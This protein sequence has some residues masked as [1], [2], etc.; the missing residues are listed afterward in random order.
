MPTSTR[1]LTPNER[2]WKRIW[3]IITLAFGSDKD[4]EYLTT[5]HEHQLRHEGGQVFPIVSTFGTRIS[6]V[7]S[8]TYATGITYPGRTCFYI[9][10]CEK[11]DWDP[12]QQY[13]T[14]VTPEVI[15]VEVEPAIN[16]YICPTCGNDRCNT[17]ERT[18][19]KCGNPL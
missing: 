12:V 17:K 3:D 8:Y 15:V 4:W 13:P 10:V 19:W 9:D 6:Q 18:C 11:T 5:N 1:T 16:N 7:S 2:G 14:P